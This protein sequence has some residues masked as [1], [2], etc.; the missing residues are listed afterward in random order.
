VQN[1]KSPKRYL[2]DYN[3]EFITVY[4]SDADFSRSMNK[5]GVTAVEDLNKQ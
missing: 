4:E 1:L 3:A 2:V 5:I